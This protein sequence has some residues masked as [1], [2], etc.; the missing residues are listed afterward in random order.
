[1]F[2]AEIIGLVQLWP[3]P[4]LGGTWPWP[5]LGVELTDL[6][7]CGLVNIPVKRSGLGLRRRK[8]RRRFSPER[9]H[10][11]LE[12]YCAFICV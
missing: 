2:Y 10:I 12:L 6:G 3:W 4:G 11:Q 5:V 8:S 9:V 7:T 1:M